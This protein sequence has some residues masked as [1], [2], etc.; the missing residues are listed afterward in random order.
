MMSR[1]GSERPCAVK[2]R[3]LACGAAR[4]L[5][6]D[7]LEVGILSGA[8]AR[9]RFAAA[10]ACARC[11]CI[12][13]LVGETESL[14]DGERAGIGEGPD[15]LLIEPLVGGVAEHEDPGEEGVRSSGARPAAEEI[16]L[17]F[18]RQLLGHG[19]VVERGGA[20]G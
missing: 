5:E 4:L 13:L 17:W 12:E 7:Q 1:I 20:R 2:Q 19:S 8:D 6:L 16:S 9:T 18:Q 10:P 14:P 11:G 15:G 3:C